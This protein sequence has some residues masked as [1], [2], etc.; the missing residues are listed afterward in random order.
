MA[1]ALK[2]EHMLATG[3]VKTQTELARLA[4]VTPA[5]ITQIMRLLD[6]APDIQEAILL[7]EPTTEHRRSSVHDELLAVA[8]RV[9]WGAQRRRW[10]RSNCTRS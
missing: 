2:M 4:H 5:R 6:L 7:A 3:E 1:L 8:S 10:N 9:D